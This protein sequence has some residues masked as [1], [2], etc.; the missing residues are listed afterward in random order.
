MAKKFNANGLKKVM[1]DDAQLTRLFFIMLGSFIL[2]CI[3]VPDK[4]PTWNNMKSMMFQ[5][6]EIGIFALAVSLGM[7]L[8]GIDLSVVSVGN[9]STIIAAL[10][11]NKLVEGGMSG[12]LAVVIGCVV[13][14]VIGCLCGTFNGLL[15]AKLGIPAMIA[16]LGAMEVFAGLGVGLTDGAAIFTPEAYAF[17][18]AGYIAGI[19]VPLII[20]LVVMVIFTIFLQKKTF[21]ME[22]YLVGTNRKAARF[23]G[24][25]TDMT[26]IRTHMAGGLLAAIGG[27]ILSSRVTS[28]KASY[29]SSY[30]LQCLLV[31]IL[32]GINPNGGFGKVPGIVMAILTLQFLSSG[33]NMM[34]ADSYFKTFIW[35][36]VLIAAMIINYYGDKAAEKKK[37]A[38]AAAKRAAEKAAA[39]AE[40]N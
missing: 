5:F 40:N 35:G 27:I 31:A 33:F 34:R 24:I 15:I 10:L 9:I 2:M 28:A 32:G 16:T 23:A 1:A 37:R 29:G 39:A 12:G 36:F 19:P 7:L 11:M 25:S 30:I 4:F 26:I 3:L 8:G 6:P 17:I 14:M 20:F 13:A 21:G 22:L 38:A 18:G